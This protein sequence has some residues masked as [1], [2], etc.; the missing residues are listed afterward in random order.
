[1]NNLHLIS[2]IK[3]YQVWVVYL[4]HNFLNGTRYNYGFRGYHVIADSQSQ[5]RQVVLDNQDSILEELKSKRNHNKKLIIRKSDNLKLTVSTNRVT[6]GKICHIL[7]TTNYKSMWSPEGKIDCKLDKGNI[8]D[9]KKNV[10]T[11]DV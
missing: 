2:M 10:D 5:A 8:V 1:M 11:V 3:N 4:G 6:S 7:S 9:I